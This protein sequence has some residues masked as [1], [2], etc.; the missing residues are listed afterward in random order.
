MSTATILSDNRTIPMLPPYYVEFDR[1]P[2]T[3]K[4]EILPSACAP[5]KSPKVSLVPDSHLPAGRFTVLQS[6][7]GVVES[8]SDAEFSAI[9]TDRTNRDNPEEEVVIEIEEISA[10]D[11]KLVKPGAVF[12]W[13]ICY[14]DAPG[15]P[16]RRV[17]QIRFR[18]LPLWS[19]RDIDQAA[20]RA[21]EV[22]AMFSD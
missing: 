13:S 15:E 5:I 21:S 2:N 14:K 11:R 1:S 7:E 6:W 20:H 10:D 8:V 19:Q 18:R 17:S 3:V 22:A 9:L 12:Y 4:G 16:R